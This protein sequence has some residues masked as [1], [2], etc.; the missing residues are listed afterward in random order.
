[1]LRKITQVDFPRSWQAAVQGN[2][3]SRTVQRVSMRSHD[4]RDYDERFMLRLDRGAR[5]KLQQLTERLGKSKAEVIRH[6]IAQA[7]LEDF[8]RSWPRAVEE[9][10]HHKARTG[11]GD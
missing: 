5:V 10:R 8:P 1:M 6:L 3:T 4:S 2:A 9:R 11:E 7:R